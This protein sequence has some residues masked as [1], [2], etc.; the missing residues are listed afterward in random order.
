MN[1]NDI[2]VDVPTWKWALALL[3][4]LVLT[5]FRYYGERKWFLSTVRLITLATLSFLLL[6]PLL[7]SVSSEVEPSTIILAYDASQSQWMSKDSVERKTALES[8][9]VHGQEAFEERGY[10]V[11]VWDFAK[12]LKERETWECEGSRTDISSA[13]EELRNKYIHRNVRAV[14]VTTDGLS[15]RGR[16][17]EYGT[18]TLDVPHFFVG[19][20]DTTTVQDIEIS[21]LLCNQ[22]T[23]LNNE[24]P[25]EVRVKSNGFEGEKA[26]LKLYL[27]S[28]V[29]DATDFT[30]SSGFHSFKFRLK[31]EAVGMQ[32]IKAAIIPLEGEER[33]ENNY[34]SSY[35]EVLDSKRKITIV[36]NAPHPDV[37]AFKESLSSNL[38]QEV[39][40]VFS[41]E[42]NSNS[43]I[44]DC[45]VVV[46]HNIP[47]THSPTLKAVTKA[48]NSDT[49]IFFAGG[50]LMDWAHI[51]L[52]RAGVSLESGKAQQEIRGGVNEG[53]GLFEIPEGLKGELAYLPPLTKAMGETKPSAALTSL[54]FQ[55]LDHLKTD[56]PLLAFNKDAIGRRSG[57]LMGE[58]FWR[59]RMESFLK[60]GNSRIIDALL[61][62]SIQY[63]DSRDDVRRFRIVGPK[64]LDED[65]RATFTSQVYDASLNP[66]TDPDISLV[67]TNE[68]GEELDFNFS[69]EKSSY[70]LDCGR[71]S[72][73]EYNWRA[74]TILDGKIEKLRGAFVVSEVKAELVSEAANHD[75]LKRL[76]V[77]TGGDLIGQL[78]TSYSND[79]G[80]EFAQFVEDKIEKRDIIHEFTERLE[81]INFKFILWLVLG[82]LTLE[83]VIRRRQ[84]GY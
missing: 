43:E 47:N 48:I 67:L 8:W 23:Y 16:D 65:E 80:D 45:D 7:R 78:S 12:Q 9:A 20:G 38:H 10:A 75:L 19:T 71:L 25:V 32:R 61:N 50:A 79:L 49:P 21:S 31:A 46:L 11:E 41:Y 83:W 74:Q 1:I 70:K 58:G 13:L 2:I 22:V 76:G 68:S 18:A 37:K 24:F 15:N 84:G 4:T 51:P 66:T 60:N 44:D 53:F 5:L 26:R 54:I 55:K 17:P 52:E 36:A 72:H 42:L 35:I 73:G 33:T 40:V 27:G 6:E 29:V 77:K 34:A 28:K 69:V 62:N 59:W 63:L 57:V 82:S 81:L 30:I 64:R 56:W 3:F 39:D 14:V